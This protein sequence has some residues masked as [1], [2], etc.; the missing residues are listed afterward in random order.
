MVAL[1]VSYEAP[2]SRPAFENTHR[3]ITESQ[4]ALNL[5]NG[6]EKNRD[7]ATEAPVAGMLVA[8]SGSE[9]VESNE[10]RDTVFLSMRRE[11]DRVGVR[12]M[13]VYVCLQQLSLKAQ[14]TRW[15]M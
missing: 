11:T 4:W 5:D 10:L 7:A 14:E 8:L 15:L 9:V 2:P 3:H 6:A 13:F 1:T 12:T